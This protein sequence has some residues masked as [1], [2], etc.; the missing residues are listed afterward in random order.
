MTNNP[1]PT[2]PDAASVAAEIVD[3]LPK[4]LQPFYIA[5]RSLL[6]D[7]ITTAILEAEARGRAF[8]LSTKHDACPFNEPCRVLE[9]TRTAL[10]AAQR[11]LEAARGQHEK[12]ALEY[13]SAVGQIQTALEEREAARDQVGAL[14]E[15]LKTLSKTRHAY[16]ECT[17]STGCICPKGA[18]EHVLAN[19]K[20]EGAW[21]AEQRREEG[22]AQERERIAK[23]FENGAVM[24]ASAQRAA[25]LDA[26]TAAPETQGEG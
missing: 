25:I 21:W 5:D 18:I 2:G 26:P 8:T 17:H 15:A 7:R 6:Q 10:T 4:R 24:G 12:D 13:I 19:L 16:Q 14:V 1:T 23:L 11:D 22:R 20:D 9:D 3:S